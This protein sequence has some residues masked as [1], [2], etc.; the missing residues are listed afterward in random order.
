MGNK[1]YVYDVRRGASGD[2]GDNGYAV[3]ICDP[4][5]VLGCVTIGYDLH[6]CRLERDST[7]DHQCG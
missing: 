1:K 2:D 5:G 4:F 3:K 6:Q 7:P